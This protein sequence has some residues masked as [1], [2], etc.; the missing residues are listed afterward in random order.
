M[1]VRGVIGFGYGI[2]ALFADATFSST[3]GLGSVLVAMLVVIL[4]GIFS[5]KQKQADLR[6]QQ[7]AGWRDLYEQERE[8]C[9]HR[10]VELVTE[11]AA[12]HVI[13]DELAATKAL[14]LVEKA[15]PDLA[16]ILDGQREFWEPLTAMLKAMQETQEQMLALLTTQQ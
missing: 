14:L 1:L 7:N 15:K 10:D 11:R 5:L 2:T 8:K 13:K 12:R 6:Q 16:V 9:E 4:F 3:I